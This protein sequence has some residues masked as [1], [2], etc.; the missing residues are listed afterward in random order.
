LPSRTWANRITAWSNRLRTTLVILTVVSALLGGAAGY[1]VFFAPDRPDLVGT[2]QRVG[3]QADQVGAF[4][5][6]FVV[7]WLTATATQRS[8]LRRFV[9]VT[10]DQLSLPT[11]P[12]AVVTTP[13]VVS[14][15][16]TGGMADADVYAVT[17]SVDERAYASAD[18]TRAFYRV[19]VVMW[20]YQPRAVTM[21]ARVDGPGAGADVATGYR[22]PLGQD[23]PVHAV[24]SGFI[25]AYLTA[26]GDLD[27]YVK[28]DAA[29]NAVGGYQSAIVSTA[30]TDRTVPEDS[31][32]GTQVHVL[33]TVLA[34]TS[35]F[36]TV[37]LTYPLRVENSGGT[38]MLAAIDLT[39]RLDDDAEPTPVAPVPH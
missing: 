14:V 15:I 16:R 29:I 24:V 1:K 35:Q 9:T 6:D 34:Q 31:P 25:R 20:N 39:P 28:A 38:W 10:D 27:R 17:V 13:Q 23:N 36:A 30:A 32:P 37:T 22:H 3:N 5:A 7:T 11:V 12:A 4:A 8:A 21:P 2:S 19:P 18:P 26:T 33:V